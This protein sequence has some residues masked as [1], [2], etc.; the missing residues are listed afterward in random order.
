MKSMNKSEK[1][2]KLLAVWLAVSA[3]VILAGIILWAILGF[4]YAAERPTAKTFEVS[5]DVVVSLGGEDADAAKLEELCTKAFE[6]AKISPESVAT[7]ESRYTTGYTLRFVFAADTSD[8]ALAAA[9]TAVEGAVE[10]VF[11]AHA[12]ISVSYH[13]LEN[14]GL[15][16]ADWRGAIAIAVGA[17]VALIYICVRFG[18]AAAVTGCV[19]CVHDALFTLSVLAIARIP[20]T[21]ASPLILA[22]IAA[23]VS[24]LLWMVFSALSRGGSKLPVN[25]A[26]D[27]LEAVVE[28]HK[29][30]VKPIAIIA[31]GA[32]IVL[33]V[34]GLVAAPGVRLFTLPALISVAAATYSSL[35]FGPALHV[36]VRRP[37]DKLFAKRKRYSGKKKSEA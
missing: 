29:S 19:N 37:F 2:V 1:S 28:A 16:V 10:T 9:K 26:A 34:V 27:S 17:V 6:D 14:E 36:H 22:G 33:L 35:L 15:T 18:F 32:A 4:N 20:V 30:A 3:V 5:Y 7:D 31:G 13:T 24:L 12:D 25:T 8:E 21:V 23:F 11:P